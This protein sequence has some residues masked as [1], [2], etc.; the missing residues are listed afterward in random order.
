[1]LFRSAAPSAL[2]DM[3][4]LVV[5]DEEVN[6]LLASAQLSRLGMRAVTVAT[7]E[8]SVELLSKGGG[9]DLVLMDLWM[10]G[11]DG[12]EATRRIR[13]AEG[14]HGRRAVII[15]V[16]ASTSTDDRLRAES[17]GMDDFLAKP[18]SLSALASTLGRWVEGGVRVPATR[19][20]EQV[21][22]VAVL[23]ALVDD[24]GSIEAV[25]QL[26][27][28][29]VDEM[30]G[31]RRRLSDAAAADDLAAARHVAH[32]MRSGALLLGAKGLGALCDRIVAATDVT[33]ARVLVG[34]ALQ[35]STAVA[36]WLQAWLSEHH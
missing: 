5:D 17:A 12:D 21:V 22:D 15:G 24:L 23:D 19:G 34:E 26:V 2:P 29:F 36:R 16:T 7:G 4:V 27:G 3:Q 30:Q 25:L 9:P 10:P 33:E 20:A 14:R 28:T 6:R 8:E 35:Q 13:A 18:V 11:I 31:R 32:T 1:M